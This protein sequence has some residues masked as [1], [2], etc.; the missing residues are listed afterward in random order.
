MSTEQPAAA[1]ERVLET[2]AELRWQLPQ[3]LHDRITETIYAE[4]ARIAGRN[5]KSE[6]A[7]ARLAWQQRVDSWLTHPVTAFPIMIAVSIYARDWL[8]T[9]LFSAAWILSIVLLTPI[10]PAIT[11]ARSYARSSTWMLEPAPLIL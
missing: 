11:V 4:A 7:S 2:A 8:T 1:P 10:F 3:N 5:V 6:G 9:S